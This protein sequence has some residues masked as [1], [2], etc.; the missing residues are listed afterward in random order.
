MYTSAE[1]SQEKL[2]T[3]GGGFALFLLMIAYNK[4]M[5]KKA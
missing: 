1:L 4:Y 5:V 3:W 2:I